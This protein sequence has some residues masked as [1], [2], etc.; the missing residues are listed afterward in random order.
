MNIPK[1][2]YYYEKNG[3]AYPEDAEDAR[4]FTGQQG[5]EQV[6]DGDGDEHSVHDVPSRGEVGIFAVEHAPGDH[7]EQHLDA[8]DDGEDVVGHG[9]EGAFQ[10]IRRNVRTLHGQRD[11]I[12]ANEEEDHVIEPLVGHQNRTPAT[13]PADIFKLIISNF[14]R[15]NS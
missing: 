7:F 10:R 1:K 6:D 3:N 12:E 5:H 8:E 11:A 14:I 15:I 13:D 9:Q 4:A 2:Y